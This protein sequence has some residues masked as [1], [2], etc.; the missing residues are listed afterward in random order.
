MSLLTVRAALEL[1]DHEAIVREWY[2]D[3]KGIGTWGI[4]VTDASGHLVERYRDNPQ[5]ILRVLEIFAWLLRTRYIPPVL[6]AFGDFDLTEEQFAAALSWHYNT[7]AILSTGW[8]P[9]VRDGH[10]VAAR[11]FM[12]THY[13]NG[14]DLKSRRMKEAA[15]FFDGKWS[16]RSTATVYPVLKPSY[17]P[18]FRHPQ[19]VDIRADM[20]KVLAE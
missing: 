16:Q 10:M 19:Q 6:K 13:L 4:G 3:S 8:V 18:D 14:G 11:T 7:G 5:P 2:R 12:E 1:V 17:Q 9:L 15:L 20:E